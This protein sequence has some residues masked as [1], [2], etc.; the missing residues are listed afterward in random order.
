MNARSIVLT[1][2][3]APSLLVT[4]CDTVKA[5]ASAKPDQLA[6]V[7]YP[8]IVVDHELDGLIVYSAPKI[9]R[10]RI[11]SVVV[12]I[13]ATTNTADLRVQYRFFFLDRNGVPIGSDQNGP[14]WRYTQLPSRSQVFLSGN[15]IDAGAEDWRLEIRPAR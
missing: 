5:P 11:M 10:A 9:E 1:V 2:A 15:A 3:L 4:G 8:Q 14:D 13:R 12:P 6:P 7:A